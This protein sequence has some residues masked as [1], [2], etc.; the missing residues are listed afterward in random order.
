MGLLFVCVPSSKK[1]NLVCFTLISQ[2]GQLLLS[3][4]KRHIHHRK[5]TYLWFILRVNLFHLFRIFSGVLSSYE[6]HLS[7]Q[8]A[9]TNEPGVLR[10]W[11]LVGA[12]LH[13]LRLV[14]PRVFYVNQRS[15]RQETADAI[16]RKCSRILPRSR[17]SFYLYEF[18]VPEQLFRE[19]SQWVSVCASS[20]STGSKILPGLLVACPLTILLTFFPPE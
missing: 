14:V 10:L 15:P 9:E 18:T 3:S 6:W 8:I 4:L 13:Q 7:P 2:F 1:R 20:L 12:E 17:P 5:L 19:H 16:W 11:A